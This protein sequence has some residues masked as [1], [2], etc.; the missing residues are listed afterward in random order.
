MRSLGIRIGIVVVLVVVA[1]ILRPYISGNA[2]DL[3]VGDC[4]DPPTDTATEVN[5]VQ[6]HPCSDPHGAE[7]FFVGKLPDASAMPDQATR[8]QWVLDNCYPA[9]QTYTGT[10]VS[11]SIDWEVAWFRPTDDGWSKGDRV[12]T[13]YAER[14]DGTKTSGSLKKTS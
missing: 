8:Q 11:T 9:Y 4:F 1:L 2:G 3:N 10:D 6:H 5:D 14:R 13:C 12:V 7:V